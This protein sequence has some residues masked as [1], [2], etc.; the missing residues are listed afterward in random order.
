VGHSQTGG[1]AAVVIVAVT[2]GL[3]LAVASLL[4]WHRCN[5]SL[6][7]CLARWLSIA[8][9]LGGVSVLPMWRITKG[10][11]RQGRVRLTCQLSTGMQALSKSG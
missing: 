1:G 10:G 9:N 11:Y 7:C 3:A 6:R 2:G 8:I 5:P 4:G